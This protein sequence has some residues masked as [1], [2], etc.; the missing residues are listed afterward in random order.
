VNTAAA[1]SL[2]SGLIIAREPILQ[3]ADAPVLLL[4]AVS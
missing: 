3:I 4:Q 2:A 1:V